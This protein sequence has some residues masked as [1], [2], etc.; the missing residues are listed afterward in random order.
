[1]IQS[2][3]NL[4][5]ICWC[6]WQIYVWVWE[7]LLSALFAIAVCLR[8]EELI[9]NWKNSIFTE[10]WSS[11]RGA[12]IHAPSP[13]SWPL[14]LSCYNVHWE[15]SRPECDLQCTYYY[16]LLPRKFA[17][18]TAFLDTILPA[19]QVHA[20]HDT[21]GM[22]PRLLQRRTKMPG[23]C[24]MDSRPIKWPKRGETLCRTFRA[25]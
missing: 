11:T 18:K 16:L 14:S 15:C 2:H 21:V 10:L 5:N 9:I 7:W 24:M 20:C 23:E 13:P 3:Q 4:S 6:V 8:S 19:L 1:M 25:S 22:Q 12:R 17:I